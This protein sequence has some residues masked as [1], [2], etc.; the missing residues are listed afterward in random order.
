MVE[1]VECDLDKDFNTLIELNCEYLS[2]AAKELKSNYDIDYFPM[3]SD[4][5]SAV[6]DY[7][8]RFV[9]DL[10][11]YSPPEGIF[12]I[13]RDNDR[14]IGMGGLKQ[15]KKGIC[16]IK[17]MYIKP[18]FRNNGFGKLMLDNLVEKAIQFG[19]KKIRLDSTRFMNKAHKLYQSY[20]FTKREPYTESENPEEFQ[21]HWVFMEK[22]L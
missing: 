12:Y 22:E 7:A 5:D 3:D 6:V 16:E 10:R 17:R 9:N 20:G 13:L 1:L 11:K 2:W 15:S 19:Y 4:F 18:I 21:N 14:T 8:K